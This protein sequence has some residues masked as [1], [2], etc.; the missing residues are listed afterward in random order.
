MPRTADTLASTQLS[1]FEGGQADIVLTPPM[2]QQL[3]T[4]M[5]ALLLEIAE[6][7]ATPE[8]GND[9]DHH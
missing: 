7:L 6:V 2:R 9:E 4:A 8:V 1:L 3:A 5:E